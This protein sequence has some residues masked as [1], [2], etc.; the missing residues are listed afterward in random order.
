MNRPQLRTKRSMRA[1]RTVRASVQ[2]N[3]EYPCTCAMGH[4]YR[5]VE[6]VV[7][8]MLELKGRSY[9]Y[10]L[11]GDLPQYA[12]TDAEIERADLY[13]T[14]RRLECNGHVSSSWDTDHSGPARRVYSLTPQGRQH[15][16][17]WAEVLA[18]VVHSMSRFL[19]LVNKPSNI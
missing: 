2:H 18:S 14:L 15:L 3:H 10:E 13:R 5:F 9:G 8:L 7:L 1:R 6:P 17:D 11:C 12:F 4:L 19:N 16:R